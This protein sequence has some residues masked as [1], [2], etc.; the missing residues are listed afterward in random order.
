MIGDAATAQGTLADYERAANL[1]QR[2]ANRVFRLRVEPQWNAT[3]TAFWYRVDTGPDSHEFIWVDAER[4]ERKVAFDH[5]KLAEAIQA[6][7][8]PPLSPPAAAT[9][10]P[11]ERLEL[12]DDRQRLRFR[13]YNADWE[14]QLSDHSLKRLG[15]PH[16]R[17]NSIGRPR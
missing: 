14:L 8:Q 12:S 1:E 15:S 4:G 6:A 11:L 10:L 3:G 7:A 2:F 17:R 5:R 13:A 16:D 9:R